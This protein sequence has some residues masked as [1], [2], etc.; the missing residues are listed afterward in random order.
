MQMFVLGVGI[1][2]LYV[3]KRRF[4]DVRSV[5]VEHN[6]RACEGLFFQEQNYRCIRFYFLHTTG[7]LEALVIICALSEDLL[8]RR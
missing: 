6:G 4:L 5:I 7:L 3:S 1:Q 2:R 8:N